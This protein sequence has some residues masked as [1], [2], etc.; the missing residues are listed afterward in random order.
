MFLKKFNDRLIEKEV[1]VNKLQHEFK[2]SEIKK[3]EA[4]V[5][6]I[7]QETLSEDTPI[8]ETEVQ[9]VSSLL[10][11]TNEPEQVLDKLNLDQFINDVKQEVSH[12]EGV[13]FVLD[14]KEKSL[15]MEIIS[16]HIYLMSIKNKKRTVYEYDRKKRNYK[17]D[18]VAIPA[19]SARHFLKGINQFFLHQTKIKQFVLHK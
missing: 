13:M 7:D 12:A 1:D 4:Q 5:A 16:T 11:E 10:S 15:Q 3:E 17:K 8:N 6:T 19:S 9:R 2:R 14:Q 18:G